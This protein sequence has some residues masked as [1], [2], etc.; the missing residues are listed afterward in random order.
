MAV[1][2]KSSKAKGGSG[3]GSRSAKPSTQ[4]KE[5]VKGGSPRTGPGGF[6]KP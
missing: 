1:K 3:G 5:K 4:P 2:R 6:I